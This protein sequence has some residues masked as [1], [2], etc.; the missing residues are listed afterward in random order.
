MRDCVQRREERVGE[1]EEQRK[2]D[3][4]HGHGVEQTGDQEE[5]A[6]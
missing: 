4:D 1:G 2:P 5:P 3:A 6:E